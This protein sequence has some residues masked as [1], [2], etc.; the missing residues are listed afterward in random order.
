[1]L[2]LTGTPG[3]SISEVHNSSE[4][5]EQHKLKRKSYG[6]KG[7]KYS[8]VSHDKHSVSPDVI[9]SGACIRSIILDGDKPVCISPLKSVPPDTFEW[10]ETAHLKVT[11]FIDGTMINLFYSKADSEWVTTTRNTIGANITFF[12]SDVF[13]TFKQMFYDALGKYYPNP[14]DF[15]GELDTHCSYS[16]VIQH[17]NHRIVT[18]VSEPNLYLTAVYEIN[19]DATIQ[20]IDPFL[21]NVLNPIP[22][23][24]PI[25]HNVPSVITPAI[26]RDIVAY[27]QTHWMRMGIHVVDMRT[28][29]R[30]KI[31][32]PEYEEMRRLRGNQPKLQ[33]R[34]LEILHNKDD[35]NKFVS[36]WPEYTDDINK[37]TEELKLLCKA[38]YQLYVGKFITHA[39]KISDIPPLY[40]KMLYSLHGIYLSNSGSV[41]INYNITYNHIISSP[42]PQIMF[43]MSRM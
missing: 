3:E 27:T 7:R 19:D 30:T 39:L 28:G 4:K 37:Y 5:M 18:P 41:K 16:F 22:R 40:R 29:M 2:N 11:E 36:V 6:Y 12:R 26:L 8:I 34:F 17:P 13:I 42:T 35:L 32:N 43:L 21:L 38:I 1:M 33:Y 23:P 25:I 9:S 10:S 31:R 14:D 24:P 15:Y 20:Y